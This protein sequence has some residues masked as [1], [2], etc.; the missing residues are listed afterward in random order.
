MEEDYM[1][2]MLNLYRAD[3]I[4]PYI[5]GQ[6]QFIGTDVEKMYFDA[7]KNFG[8]LCSVEVMN[9][10]TSDPQ[11]RPLEPKFVETYN[12]LTKA[13]INCISDGRKISLSE[14]GNAIRLVGDYNEAIGAICYGDTSNIGI[15]YGPNSSMRLED[16][17]SEE[18]RTKIVTQ[19]VTCLNALRN[20]YG[21]FSLRS[22][23]F[24]SNNEFGK[25][26]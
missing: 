25:I 6:N 20:T 14:I 18:S 12:Q 19:Y 23:L 9:Y 17:L 5:I 1:N 10:A 11:N 24:K 21:D 2:D 22:E 3:N 13:F 7:A 4:W 8:E 16:Y 26:K 15:S